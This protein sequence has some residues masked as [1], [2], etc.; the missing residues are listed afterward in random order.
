MREVLLI[1]VNG[2]NQISNDV[3]KME[4]VSCCDTTIPLVVYE[5]RV[6][7]IKYYAFIPFG[8]NRMSLGTEWTHDLSYRPLHL[9]TTMVVHLILTIAEPTTVV[10]QNTRNL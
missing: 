1:V 5:I 6:G 7:S 4:D 10:V 9:E 2:W 3:W 8:S